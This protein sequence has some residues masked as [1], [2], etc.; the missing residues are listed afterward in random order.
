MSPDPGAL[1][2]VAGGFGALMAPGLALSL[3]AVVVGGLALGGAIDRRD[4]LL[5]VAVF[6][7]LFTAATA[8]RGVGT[9][10]DAA[11]WVGLVALVAVIVCL[12]AHSG[13]WRGPMAGLVLS[14]VAILWRIELF[15]PVLLELR[16]AWQSVPVWGT[17]A[18]YHL[19]TALA[20]AGVYVLATEVGRNLPGRT[21]W[22]PWA[23]TRVGAAALIATGTWSELVQTLLL[24][25]PFAPLG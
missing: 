3:L 21:S 17:L 10:G 9:T 2:A 5:A 14:V 22:L 12:R 8:R 23:V 6:V 16:G 13:L 24:R 11:L 4:H 20:L 18:L 25:W 1:E 7:V 19:A 15:G